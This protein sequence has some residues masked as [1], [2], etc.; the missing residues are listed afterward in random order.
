MSSEEYYPDS[1]NTFKAL[2]VVARA[3]SSGVLFRQAA[4]ISTVTG[5]E[6][7]SFLCKGMRCQ[8][9]VAAT[10]H[11]K[12]IDKDY[13]VYSGLKYQN[14]IP[15]KLDKQH[16]IGNTLAW[17]VQYLCRKVT[18]LS[19]KQSLICCG[20]LLARVFGY[21]NGASVSTRSLS[22]GMTPSSRIFLTPFSDLSFHKY[23]VSP[24]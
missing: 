17:K 10:P 3:T 8:Y 16:N 5:R 23:P 19:V 14:K 1:P 7:G 13:W 2:K 9:C 12:G 22:R 4:I 24:I 18:D 6:Q 21:M 11:C 15:L 20:S